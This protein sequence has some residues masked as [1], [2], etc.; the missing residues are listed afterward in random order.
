VVGATVA[1]LPNGDFEYEV[2]VEDEEDVS[3]SDDE[4]GE[5][6]A[7]V[8][9]VTQEFDFGADIAGAAGSGP[10]SEPVSTITPALDG[11][12]RSAASRTCDSPA[13]FSVELVS[14]ESAGNEWVLEL[15]G[16]RLLNGLKESLES[17]TNMGTVRRMIRRKRREGHREETWLCPRLTIPH[18]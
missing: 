13:I 1:F 15:I 6:A 7:N 5:G 3:P 14:V 12:K 11:K 10:S 2:T 16:K 17:S 9:D 18:V 4:T 8:G